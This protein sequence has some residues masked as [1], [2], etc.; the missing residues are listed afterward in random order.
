MME[1]AGS[2][3]DRAGRRERRLGKAR[4]LR[5]ECS[6]SG[7]LSRC[8]AAQINWTA[9]RWRTCDAVRLRALTG[10]TRGEEAGGAAYS[11]PPARRT[12]GRAA[13]RAVHASRSSA[14]RQLGQAWPDRLEAFPR[15]PGRRARARARRSAEAL[16]RPG[17]FIGKSSDLG[18]LVTDIPDLSDHASA[19]D[20]G[21]KRIASAA[22]GRST[23]PR[24]RP[25][26]PGRGKHHRGS[27][28][29]S[30]RWVQ[31]LCLPCGGP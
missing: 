5:R 20:S 21:R 1:G 17:G 30:L 6:S 28:A 15:E 27:N 23:H 13:R 4:S 9:R 7:L 19:L 25:S 8:T 12:S 10:G 11:F 16:T 3:C 22:R 14:V 24:Q 18:A 2:A 26:P 29:V 31:S